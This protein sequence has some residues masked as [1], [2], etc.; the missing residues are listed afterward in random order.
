VGHPEVEIRAAG[1][2]PV[3]RGQQWLGIQFDSDQKVWFGAKYVDTD[4]K[5]RVWWQ[6]P[7]TAKTRRL[8]LA[9]LD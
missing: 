6:D 1:Y 4:T 7:T 2:T 9:L 5:G 8:L 3:K